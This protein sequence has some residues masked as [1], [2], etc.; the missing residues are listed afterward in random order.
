MIEEEKNKIIESL[1][2]LFEKAGRICLELRR[3]GLKKEIKEDNTPVTNGDIEVNNLIT[4]EIKKITAGVVEMSTYSAEKFQ[5][6]ALLVKDYSP[7][8][9]TKQNIDIKLSKC[10]SLNSDSEFLAKIDA[11]SKL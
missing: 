2:P 9:Y 6:V 11:I 1:I 8:T 3:Q 5:K 4:T 10:F 7:N